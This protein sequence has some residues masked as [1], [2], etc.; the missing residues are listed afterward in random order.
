MNSK[1]NPT[2]KL[3]SPSPNYQF[4][5][6]VSPPANGSKRQ[7]K[8]DDMTSRPLRAWPFLAFYVSPI[9]P[10]TAFPARTLQAGASLELFGALRPLLA[11]HSLHATWALARGTLPCTECAMFTELSLA[12]TIPGTWERINQCWINVFIWS[13]AK[14]L[15]SIPIAPFYC[16]NI[17]WSFWTQHIAAPCQNNIVPICFTKLLQRS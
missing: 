8:T 17:I 6:L 1:P 16:F 2:L 5:L 13:S 15:C 14:W 7:D 10:G 12:G 9:P 4:I 3:F 11:Q